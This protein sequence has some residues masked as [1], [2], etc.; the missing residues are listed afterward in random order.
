[1]N[2]KLLALLMCMPLNL[3]AAD[4]IRRDPTQEPRAHLED[5]PEISANA[6]NGW[7]KEDLGEFSVSFPPE[8]KY[9][10]HSGIDSFCGSFRTKTLTVG[11]CSSTHP[12]T[13]KSYFEGRNHGVMRRFLVA[14]RAADF[15]YPESGFRAFFHPE[16]AGGPAVSFTVISQ[17]PKDLKTAELILRTVRFPETKKK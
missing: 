4:K 5:R 12:E 17:L 3:F 11:F 7:L 13:A 1:M 14:N 16:Y 8:M 10:E 6:P 2:I 15:V 9:K